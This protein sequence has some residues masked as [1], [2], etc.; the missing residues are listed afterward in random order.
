MDYKKRIE[1]IEML[2]EPVISY[3]RNNYDPY[4]SIVISHDQIKLVRNEIGIPVKG[5]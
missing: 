2:C 1:E 5:D 3:L 4:Y